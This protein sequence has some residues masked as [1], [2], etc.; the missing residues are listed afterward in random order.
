[1]WLYVLKRVPPPYQQ[2]VESPF[3]EFLNNS[4]GAHVQSGGPFNAIRGI[5]VNIGGVQ[6]EAWVQPS[7]SRVSFRLQLPQGR[8]RLKM[9]LGMVPSCWDKPGDGLVGKVLINDVLLENLF[10]ETGAIRG[11]QI[12]Q[13]FRARTFFLSKPRTYFMQFI[14]AQN[15]PA[16]RE[17]KEISLD[18]STFSGKVVDI[19]FEVAGGPRGDDRNDEALWAAPIIE[20]Y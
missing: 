7:P 20:S 3:Y 16:D 11:S 9:A 12:R 13:F 17:W 15:N 5:S 4:S 2:A 1:M 8:S 19:T 10:R 18:L 6:K 14:D